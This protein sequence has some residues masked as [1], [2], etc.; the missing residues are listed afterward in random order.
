MMKFIYFF[1]GFGMSSIYMNILKSIAPAIIA[2]LR[3][4]AGKSDNTIDDKLVTILE[5]ILKEFNILGK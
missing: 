1:L 4:E 2:L 5:T 3:S